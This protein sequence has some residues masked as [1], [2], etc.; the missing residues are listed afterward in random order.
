MMIEELITLLRRRG[1][2]GLQGCLVML[3]LLAAGA[4]TFGLLVRAFCLGSGVC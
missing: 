3:L 2:D 4:V 1:M